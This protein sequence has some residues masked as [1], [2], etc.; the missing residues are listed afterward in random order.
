VVALT[1][2]AHL[3]IEVL[4]SPFLAYLG[5]LQL[6][7]LNTEF[8]PRRGAAAGGGGPEGFPGPSASHVLRRRAALRPGD[9]CGRHARG[10]GD[11]GPGG[12]EDPA[13]TRQRCREESGR[14]AAKA[15]DRF[16]DK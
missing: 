4:F 10:H 14:E 1:C 16:V 8:F 5:I 12:G 6:V 15:G 13:A 7:A 2:C 11:V 3:L 9:G